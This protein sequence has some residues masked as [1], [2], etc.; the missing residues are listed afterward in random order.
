VAGQ[1]A[2][3]DARTRASASIAQAKT[4]LE[5]ALLEIDLIQTFDPA[6]VGLL[7]HALTNYITVT[8][9][10]V[11]MLQLSLRGF[12]DPDVPVWLEGIGHTA[13][14]M[15]HSVSRLVSMST[16]RDFPLKLDRVNLTVL[17]GRA[18]EYYRQ[19]ASDTGVHISCNAVGL[20]PLVWADRVAVAVVADNLLS[21]AVRLSGDHGSVRVQ[22]MTEPGH[23]VCSI[24][25]SGPGLTQ[26]VRER[27][28]EPPRAA[29]GNGP[30]AHS[31][32]GLSIAAEF[33]RRMDGDLWCESEPVKGAC[34]S[35]RLPAI[36]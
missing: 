34:F 27:M 7:A 17:L 29:G 24:R 12:H 18:C 30:A 21:N 14:M 11:E 23:V 26:E 19:R 1:E 32:Y 8:S 4:E 16:P 35:F 10:T 5:R 20:V 9:A 28:F 22:I 33:V 6:I 2:S 13:D 3:M 15:Q 31:G 25:D 36:E